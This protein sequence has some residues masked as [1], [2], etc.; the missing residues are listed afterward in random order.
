M[1]EISIMKTLLALGAAAIIFA[2]GAAHPRSASPSVV[3]VSMQR[4]VAQSNAGKR[5]MQQLDTLR[6]ERTRELTA[7]QKELEEVTRQLAKADA[8]ER[9]RLSQDESRRRAELQQLASQA[10]VDFLSAQSK[11]QADVRALLAPIL[12]DI[13]KRYGLDVVLNSD[14]GVAWAVPGSD[15]TDE[16]IKRLNVA[17]Q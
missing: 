9:D 1:S 14:T 6:Q 7:R 13:A 12:A 3:T 4:V 2:I 5:A 10:N 17:P 15:A 11:L 8:A 16:V